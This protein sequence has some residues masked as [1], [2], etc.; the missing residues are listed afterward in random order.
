MPE[1]ID[2]LSL[3]LRDSCTCG[4]EGGSSSLSPQP[5]NL[6]EGFNDMVFAPLPP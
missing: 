6:P 4:R 2:K 3:E 5:G 1:P